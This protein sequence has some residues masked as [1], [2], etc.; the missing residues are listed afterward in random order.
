MTFPLL[1]H[2]RQ[3]GSVVASEIRLLLRKVV[4][5]L[6]FGH[7]TKEPSSLVR[8]S[9]HFTHLSPKENTRILCQYGWGTG[10]FWHIQAMPLPK[11]TRA[12]TGLGANCSVVCLRGDWRAVD[13]LL[14]C[15][16]VTGG[17]R[18]MIPQFH[19]PHS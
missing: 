11:R 18:E 7:I 9:S 19:N 16:G 13:L 1:L 2:C 3:Q 12:A 8:D 14:R 6:Y 15:R 10:T 17:G 5:D 4:S